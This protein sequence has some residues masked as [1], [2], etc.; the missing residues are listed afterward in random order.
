MPEFP[1]GEATV[2]VAALVTVPPRHY[3]PTVDLVVVRLVPRRLGAH[4]T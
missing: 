3:L 2:G 4:R 1:S